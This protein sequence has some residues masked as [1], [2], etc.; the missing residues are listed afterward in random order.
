MEDDIPITI[1]I[2]LLGDLYEGKTSIITMYTNK[3]FIS[4]FQIEFE[5]HKKEIEINN[6]KIK[7][8]YLGYC[9]F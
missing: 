2:K 4:T 1:P 5:F 7:I 3:Q 9:S 8:E 6:I